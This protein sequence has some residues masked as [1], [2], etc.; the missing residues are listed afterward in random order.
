MKRFS[1]PVALCI[2]GA[3]AVATA[4]LARRE[5]V[6]TPVL[7]AGSL[8]QIL[9]GIYR[10]GQSSEPPAG[11]AVRAAVVP[12]H[13][14]A[15]ETIAT[16]VRALTGENRETILLLSPDHFGRCP[17]L[18][19][20][21]DAS[22][23]TLTGDVAHDHAIVAALRRSPLVTVT[24]APFAEE[25]GI[26]GVLPF[27]AR[28]LP[29]TR[30]V[31]VILSQK[32]PW[33]QAKE[34]LAALLAPHVE[35]GATLVVS[36]DFS[37]DL[38][39]AEADRADADTMAMFLAGDSDGIA[40]LRN[41]AQDDCPGC[42]WILARLAQEQGFFNPSIL[43]RS[44]SA[45]ILQEESIPKTTL[46]PEGPGGGPES[47][48]SGRDSLSQR[49]SVQGSTSHF[50]IAFF[51]NAVLSGDDPA[52][53]GDVTVARGVPAGGRLPP[54][55]AAFW[56]GK[57][58]RVLNL[59]GPLSSSCA[60]SDNPFIFCNATGS[61][62]RIKGLAQ[63]WGIENNHTLDQGMGGYEETRRLLRSFGVT[64]LGEQPLETGNI[65][66][67]AATALLNPVP[68]APQGFAPA[69][70]RAMRES[71][72]R[73]HD[74]KLDVVFLHAG[75]EEYAAL[76]GDGDGDL[77]RSFIDAGADAVVVLHSHVVGDMEIYRGKP[78]FRGIGNFLFDQWQSAP[79]RT[80]KAVRLRLE[81][82]RVLFETFV[83]GRPPVS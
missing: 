79:T 26:G 22:F 82:S 31:P 21:T 30:V 56:A 74:G 32:L 69:Q 53:G 46:A 63:E 47:A 55:L 41:P 6:V 83:A 23:H 42:L 65:R 45:R 24:D 15:A 2:L 18:L 51:A 78:I 75:R 70:I 33:M 48:W 59:E 43:L 37:H 11:Y 44:N 64:A 68:D 35:R 76:T 36:S 50:A 25:H 60:P 38:P 61:F 52:F 73:L 54:A 40:R 17:T 10:A 12:H 27:I 13:L 28:E 20:T 16:G 58:V 72:R 81:G 77:Y 67:Y 3:V 39:L 1:V 8:Q 9:E 29:G 80:T 5:R 57:G 49:P 71:V 7:P 4:F 62:L 34:E 14:T 19:C 66:L